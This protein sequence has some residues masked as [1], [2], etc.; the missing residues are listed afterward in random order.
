M[1]RQ[2]SKY[3]QK[4]CRKGCWSIACYRGKR[5]WCYPKLF[6]QDRGI[7]WWA[8]IFVAGLIGVW[9]MQR[10]SRK[11][12]GE[13]Q[14]YFC[15]SFG[16]SAG[17]HAACTLLIWY[18]WV[19]FSR[20]QWALM[21]FLYHIPVRYTR[22]CHETTFPLPWNSHV[23]LSNASGL[24]VS[25]SMRIRAGTSQAQKCTLP[26]SPCLALRMCVVQVYR[27]GFWGYICTFA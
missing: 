14:L 26:W 24:Q 16:Q 8:C 20:L 4:T 9:L 6:K 10:V 7:C 11:Q 15:E 25:V 1:V 5:C 19:I 21:M 22:P 17:I 12:A 2:V 27:W 23:A 13:K 18:F 3:T